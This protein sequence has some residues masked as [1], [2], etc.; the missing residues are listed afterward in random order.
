[1]EVGC[2]FYSLSK[3]FDVTGM[4]VSFFLGSKEIVDNFVKLR[5]L[6]DFG[7][8]YPIQYGAIKALEVSKEIVEEQR[9]EYQ[10]RRDA[11]CD[12]LNSI[13]WHIYKPK[14]TMFVFAKIPN[15]YKGSME[16]TEDLLEKTGI[17]VNPGIAFGDLGDRY[18]RFALTKTVD[19]FKEIVD[20]IAKSGITFD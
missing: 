6:Y 15:H 13:G 19:Q 3:S 9:L 18:V 2:E 17:L 12:G 10:A 11:L 1:M 7:M 8:F 5:S 14:G 4:R 16:F 20:I